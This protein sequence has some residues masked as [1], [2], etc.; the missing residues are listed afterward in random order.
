MQEKRNNGSA[1]IPIHRKSLINTKERERERER[2]QFFLNWLN[3][4]SI[5]QC[6]SDNHDVVL[7]KRDAAPN[8][9][10]RQETEIV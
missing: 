10:C 5:K 1:I 4:T 2:F 9:P 7:K 3:V 8:N 6:K